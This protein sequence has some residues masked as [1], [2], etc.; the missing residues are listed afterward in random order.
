MASQPEGTHAV[1][2][3]TRN[4]AR[5]AWLSVAAAAV[6]I[7]L[8]AGAYFVTGSVGLL[9]DAAESLV[10]LVAAFVA[11]M[12]LRQVQ[13][14]ADS[15]YSFGR[16][17]AEYFSSGLEGGMILI[18]AMVIIVES[19]MRLVRPAQITNL[20]FGL[21]ATLIATAI[22]GAVGIVLI[23][24]GRK[25]R[26]PTL[27]ADGSH[28]LTDVVTSI[29][30]I[31]GVGLVAVT[32]WQ[33]LDP[34]VALVVACN[35]MVVG[36]RLVRHALAGLMDAGLPEEDLARIRRVLAQY[37]EQGLRFHGLQTRVSGSA[38]FANVDVLVPGEWSVRQGHEIAESVGA[39]MAAEI[40][41]LR[42]FVHVEPI[43]DPVSYQD[44]PTG[45]VPLASDMEAVEPPVRE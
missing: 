10:N 21:V 41:G 28:L 5:Y 37:R 2:S 45:S 39:A 33:K 25:H 18:A 43:E 16:S 27:K 32:G 38:S 24:A 14:P 26:S 29:G 20:G 17:K 3:E 30:V 35:I 15:R 40:E 6:T 31:V 23:R 19:V 9:S 13:R 34:I 12:V 7:A 11:V 44:I 22:N 8:K 42:V 1:N 36:V 4:L